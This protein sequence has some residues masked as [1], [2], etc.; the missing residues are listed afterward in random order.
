[1]GSTRMA[2]NP[3]LSRNRLSS[4]MVSILPSLSMDNLS[5]H[6]RGFQHDLYPKSFDAASTNPF[7]THNKTRGGGESNFR[8]VRRAFLSPETTEL[9]RIRAP[10]LSFLSERTKP[11]YHS[12]G[13]K[14]TGLKKCHKKCPSDGFQF[15]RQAYSFKHEPS[16]G[17]VSGMSSNQAEQGAQR[18][19]RSKGRRQL[20][21]LRSISRSVSHSSCESL[22]RAGRHLSKMSKRASRSLSDSSR[23][24]LTKLREGVHEKVRRS[25]STSLNSLPP[26]PSTSPLTRRHRRNSPSPSSGH[27]RVAPKPPGPSSSRRHC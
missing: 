6:Y 26:P 5:G 23:R 25:R 8:T 13:S 3:Y 17:Y 18:R 4:S 10:D 24:G 16:E 1:M 2:S 22:K 21:G 14:G 15:G 7:H 27:R 12:Q 11:E 19:S 20:S 9:G